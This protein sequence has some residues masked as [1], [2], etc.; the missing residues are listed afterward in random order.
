MKIV[1]VGTEYNVFADDLK[2]YDALPPLTYVVDFDPRRGFWLTSIEPIVVKEKLYGPHE[3]KVDKIMGNFPKFPRSLG[4]ILSG[5]KG[6]GKSICAKLISQ[7]AMEMGYPVIV[8]NRY[9]VGI[10]EFISSIRQEVVVLFDEFDKTFRTRNDEEGGRV[11]PQDSLLTLFDGTDMGKKLFVVTCNELD[12]LNSL[13]VNR[14]GRFHYHLRFD[15]PSDDEIREYMKDNVPE[16]KYGEIEK[17]VMFGKR[18]RLNYD[19][20]RSIA[21]ELSEGETF[22]SCIADLNIVGDQT[23]QHYEAIAITDDS[24]KVGVADSVRMNFLDSSSEFVAFE[25]NKGLTMQACI[26]VRNARYDYYEGGYVLDADSVRSV[27]WYDRQGNEL[28]DDGGKPFP[29]IVKLVFK[30]R[31]ASDDIHYRFSV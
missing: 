2:T 5:S 14:P 8:V 22:E 25:F 27:T 7:R 6:I 20:L 23:W 28:D 17:V 1:N 10:A 31:V 11:F 13:L 18:F 12:G 24:K 19:C 15:C 9:Y 29:S 21:F 3:S 16:S 4:V 26:L 30:R